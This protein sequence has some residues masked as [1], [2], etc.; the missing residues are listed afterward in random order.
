MLVYQ[1]VLW[2]PTWGPRGSS[3]I[4]AGVGFDREMARINFN[5]HPVARIQITYTVKI[6]YNTMGFEKK[7]LEKYCLKYYLK[8]KNYKTKRFIG[9]INMSYLYYLIIIIII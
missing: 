3:F 9:N 1:R 6:N 4:K 2:L 8:N 7:Y 5:F